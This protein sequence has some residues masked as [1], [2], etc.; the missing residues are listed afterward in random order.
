MW[1][2]RCIEEFSLH[3]LRSTIS[4]RFPKLQSMLCHISNLGRCDVHAHIT[5]LEYYDF[6][7]SVTSPTCEHFLCAR[8]KKKQEFSGLLN[9][10][11]WTYPLKIL[12]YWARWAEWPFGQYTVKTHTVNIYFFMFLVLIW[13]KY[14]EGKI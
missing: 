6:T 14:A 11:Q 9:L 12:I 13:R 4:R 8:R 10:E 2:Y 1:C 5:L 3:T 7:P